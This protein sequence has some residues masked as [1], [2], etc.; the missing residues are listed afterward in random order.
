MGQKLSAEIVLAEPFFKGNALALIK[1]GRIEDFIAD[2]R[3]L[4]NQLVGAI[5]VGEVDRVSREL[6]SSFIK[7]PNEKIGFL[8]GNK[9]LK[10]GDRIVLQSSNFTPIDKAIVVTQNV[11]FKGKYVIITS[12]NKRISFSKNVKEKETKLELLNLLQN[13]EDSRIKDVGIIFRS[14]C[15]KSSPEKILKD[16]K[17]QLRK[18]KDVFDKK[19]DSI[20]QLVKAPNALQKA[21]IEWD[22][23]DDP[24]INKV[25]GCF[26]NF[27]VWEQILALRSE[28]VNLP[29]GGNL[30]IEKT[31]AFVAI[32]I[33]TSKSSSLNSALTVNIEAVKEIPR[34]LRLRGL[35]GKVIIE[36]GPLSKKY[37][38]KIEETLIL[39][40]LSSDKLRIAGWTNLGNLELEKPRDRFFL[41]NDEFNQI[42]KNLLE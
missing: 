3:N 13:F 5:V 33:N 14:I 12:K 21:Y 9:H 7:L 4:E 10:S 38:K 19:N 40:S 25:K 41:S 42:E 15:I 23:F 26:D 8:K 24:D 37:R 28:I 29:S 31:Q 22:K 32:D 20:C 18:Y 16:L 6:N 39:N 36:F 35:G 27:S 17:E 34:Q 11:S 1:N 30:I 2:F